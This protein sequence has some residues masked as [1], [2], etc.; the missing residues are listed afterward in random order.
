MDHDQSLTYLSTVSWRSIPIVTTTLRVQSPGR[1]WVGISL[2]LFV[3]SVPSIEVKGV[4]HAVLA[5][6]PEGTMRGGVT[7]LLPLTWQLK[8]RFLSV[9]CNMNSPV[10]YLSS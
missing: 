10:K 2:P 6:W 5:S 4:T 8:K 7:G 9:G 3:N 1:A